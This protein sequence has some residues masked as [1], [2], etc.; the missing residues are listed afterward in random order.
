MQ[1]VSCRRPFIRP[2]VMTTSGPVGPKCAKALGL[3]RPA[4]PPKPVGLMSRAPT[5]DPR[6]LSLLEIA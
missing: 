5:H 2:F 1:C 4:L 3:E 6:Q